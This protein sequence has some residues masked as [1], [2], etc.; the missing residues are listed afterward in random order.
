MQDLKITKAGPVLTFSVPKGTFSYNLA[1]GETIGLSGRPVES[2]ASQLRGASMTDVELAFEDKH[3]AELF[4]CIRCAVQD[5][6][7]GVVT[8]PATVFAR[9][10]RYRNLEQYF[11]AEVSVSQAMYRIPMNEVPKWLIKVSKARDIELTPPKVCLARE[12]AAECQKILADDDVAHYFGTI[13]LYFYQNVRV[14]DEFAKHGYSLYRIAKYLYWLARYEGLDAP[15]RN[16]R[17]L[18]DY[19]R[20]SSALYRKY[21]KYPRCFETKRQIVNYNYH[22][23]SS[24]TTFQRDIFVSMIDTRLDA[25]IDGYKFRHARSC[26]EMREYAG[27]M[28]NCLVSY[29]KDVCEGKCNIVF[30]EYPDDEHRLLALEVRNGRIVQVEGICGRMINPYERELRDKYQRHL[31]KALGKNQVAYEDDMEDVV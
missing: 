1:T 6:A 23:M 17:E 4:R 11:A 24:E 5:D 9:W 13:A 12:H 8:A 29:I 3:Y 2:L 18:A 10:R 22:Q 16:M 7:Y 26:D 19:A 15:E 30:A 25:D 20:Q 27:R 14:N 28:H 31:N 21:D